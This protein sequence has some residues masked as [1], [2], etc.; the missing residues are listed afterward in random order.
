MNGDPYL[1]YCLSTF[2]IY[3]RIYSSD[4]LIYTRELQ[5]DRLEAAVDFPVVFVNQD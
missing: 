3:R 1:I 5:K 2:R 4:G